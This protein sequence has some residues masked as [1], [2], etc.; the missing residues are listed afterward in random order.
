MQKKIKLYFLNEMIH[1]PFAK[2]WG[3][4]I[5]EKNNIEIIDKEKN[6][7][8]YITRTLPKFYL[9]NIISYSVK[10]KVSRP[11][12]LW[13]HE[14]RYN[15]SIF[16][17]IKRNMFK[18]E[19][20]IMN[21]YNG[22]V[23]VNNYNVYGENNINEYLNTFKKDELAE[24]INKAVVFASY[25]YDTPKQH[26]YI[27]GKDIDLAIIRQKIVFEAYNRSFVDIYGRRWPSKMTLEE[28]SN[29]C[30]F[31]KKIAKIKNYKFNICIEN[32]DF[33]FYVSEKIWHSIKARTLP[34]YRGGGQRIYDDFPKNS[35]IDINDFK[36]NNE[37]LDYLQ[38]ISDDD[39]C[40]RLNKCIETYIRLYS[41][42]DIKKQ[43]E[44]TCKLIV[45]KIKDIYELK[46]K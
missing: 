21:I 36:S 9:K 25:V 33:D 32:T 30:L 2:E 38:N 44:L 24:R 43:R 10:H 35:F 12:L 17:F 13:T 16:P 40:S 42:L 5:L 3:I 45:E 11:I 15:T 18:P 7:D 27:N 28:E 31:E 41:K 19:V 39:Y 22:N 6:A 37:L 20:H 8:I 34:I 26:L 4:D 46:I 23:F 14:P 1:T 29:G